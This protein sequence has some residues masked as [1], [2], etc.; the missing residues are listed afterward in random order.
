MPARA[1]RPL[2]DVQVG[3]A[4]GRFDHEVERGPVVPEIELAAEVVL[5]HISD[6]PV[7]LGRAS[8]E[9]GPCPIERGLGKISDGDV[10]VA[11]LDELPGKARRSATDVK[12]RPVGGESDRIDQSQRSLRRWLVPADLLGGSLPIDA[13]PVAL[14]IDHRLIVTRIGQS[15]RLELNQRPF[16]P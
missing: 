13:L 1:Q 9:L 12:D 3:V 10:R 7:D 14:L 2:Q 4:I 8:S 11:G 6:N 16:G 15:G 5:P